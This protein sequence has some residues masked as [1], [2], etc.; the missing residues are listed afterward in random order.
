MGGYKKKTDRGVKDVSALLAAIKEV[1][2]ENKKPFS[3]A[4]SYGIVYNSF[5]RYIQRFEKRIP[6]ISQATYDKLM[7]V[8]LEISSYGAPTV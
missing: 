3:V 6:D 5:K 7:Q 2:I 4:A 8:V 1:K